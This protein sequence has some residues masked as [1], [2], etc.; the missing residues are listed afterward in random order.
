MTAVRLLHRVEWEA[1]LRA[2]ECRPCAEG[3]SRKLQTAEWWYSP[4]LGVFTVPIDQEGRCD[5]WSLAA[6]LAY[7]D[8]GKY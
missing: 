4:R 2:R 6:L 8:S 1:K 3:Q 5:Q 7:L